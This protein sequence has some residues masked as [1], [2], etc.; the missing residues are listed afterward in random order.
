MGGWGW[1]RG[2][3]KQNSDSTSRKLGG[4]KGGGGDFVSGRER[5][6]GGGVAEEF[7]DLLG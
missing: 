4:K 3:G 1:R 5:E 7:V 2:M 6:G